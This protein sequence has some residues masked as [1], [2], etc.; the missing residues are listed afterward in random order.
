[1]QFL[2][3]KEGVISICM[4]NRFLIT[5][6]FSSH[7]IEMISFAKMDMIIAS[8]TNILQKIPLI[9]H[10]INDKASL[11]SATFIATCPKL[12]TCESVPK[13]PVWKM[14]KAKASDPIRLPK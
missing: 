6:G 2:S 9:K 10:S 7:R 13:S 11:L 8:S 4:N 3:V 5:I 1:M 12:L 14:S